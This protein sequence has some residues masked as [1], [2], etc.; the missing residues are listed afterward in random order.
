MYTVVVNK[1]STVTLSALI[2][3]RNSGERLKMKNIRVASVQFEHASGN[4]Q[5]NMEK[6][7]GFVR[8]ASSRN[9]PEC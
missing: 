4:K 9:V 6:L 8:K 1:I 7:R 3:N 2:K 5:A